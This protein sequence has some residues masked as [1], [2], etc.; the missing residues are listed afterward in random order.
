MHPH[1]SPQRPVPADAAAANTLPTSAC[2]FEC[3]LRRQQ[4]WHQKRTRA[5]HAPFSPR[6]SCASSR[7]LDE[8]EDYFES[9]ESLKQVGSWGGQGGRAAAEPPA[10]HTTAPSG[11]YLGASGP[12]ASYRAPRRGPLRLQ[13]CYEPQ[14]ALQSSASLDLHASGSCLLLLPCGLLPE[15]L[16]ELEGCSAASMHG[17]GRGKGGDGWASGGGESGV[18]GVRACVAAGQPLPCAT[19]QA[20]LCSPLPP[21]PHTMPCRGTAS[22]LPST[23]ACVVSPLLHSCLVP[24]RAC[25][26]G[27]CSEP[28]PLLRRRGAA[29][30]THAPGLGPSPAAEAGRR[31]GGPWR[32]AP[33]QGFAAWK[34]QWPRWRCQHWGRGPGHCRNGWH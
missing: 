4:P 10:K 9:V 31:S 34:Y 6:L 8:E 12:D 18:Q 11:P 14:T 19:C 13:M 29:L 22:S 30:P 26:G 25:S 15:E 5:M 1:R 27:C 21:L 24:C 2:P 3:P 17:A 7:V 32:R 33:G 23:N 20:A 16:A 28:D